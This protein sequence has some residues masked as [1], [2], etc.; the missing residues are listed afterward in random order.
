[1]R[2]YNH[3]YAGKAV[4]ITYYEYAFLALGILYAM[5]MRQ[6]VIFQALKYFSTLYHNQQDFRKI[7]IVYEMCVLIFSTIFV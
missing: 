7:V 2:S 6:V 1:V 5:R 4:S 3:C